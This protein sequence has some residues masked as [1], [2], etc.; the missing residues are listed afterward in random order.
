MSDAPI[1][2][3][4]SSKP[5]RNRPR[6][7]D[8]AKPGWQVRGPVRGQ[9]WALRCMAMGHETIEDVISCVYGLPYGTID[10]VDR[11]EVYSAMHKVMGLGLAE[12]DDMLRCRAADECKPWVERMAANGVAN[13]G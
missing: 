7:A 13:D 3:T 10:G 6:L 8:G 2:P 5:A 1:G 12:R 11:H 4:I 9:G